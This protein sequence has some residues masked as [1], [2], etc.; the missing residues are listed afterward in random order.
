MAH[1][2]STVRGNRGA[3]SRTGSK[4]SGMVAYVNGWDLGIRA[5]ISH[6]DGRD[7][8]RVYRTGGSNGRLPV[9]LI[10]EFD[11]EKIDITGAL[12]RGEE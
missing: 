6:R 10:A 5:E 1:F 9:Q 7:V 12:R 3:A 8:V 2:Y 4:N 11:A